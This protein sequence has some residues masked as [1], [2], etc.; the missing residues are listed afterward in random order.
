M[1]V[2]PTVLQKVDLEVD[3]RLASSIPSASTA[4][5]LS[6]R[7]TPEPAATL[8]RREQ[9]F[10]PVGRWLKQ[11]APNTKLNKGHVMF[12]SSH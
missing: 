7:G 12:D 10:V 1:R 3:V 8:I 11:I 4:G 6:S 2:N 9:V 5:T